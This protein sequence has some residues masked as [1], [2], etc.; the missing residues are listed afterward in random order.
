MHVTEHRLSFLENFRSHLDM[1][2]GTLLEQ[3]LDQ[4]DPEVPANSNPSGILRFC[5]KVQTISA[6]SNEHEKAFI[7]E[8]QGSMFYY[9][10]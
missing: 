3:G 8:F 10:I 4:M 7:H 2:L 5:Y 6:V 9:S 1:V